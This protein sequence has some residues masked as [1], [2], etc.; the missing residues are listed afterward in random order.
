MLDAPLPATCCLVLV[1]F[2]C[3]QISKQQGHDSRAKQSKAEQIEAE[4][5]EARN[6]TKANNPA[7]IRPGRVNKLNTFR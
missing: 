6:Q 7:I 4:Q 1:V 2:A 5:S 3:V